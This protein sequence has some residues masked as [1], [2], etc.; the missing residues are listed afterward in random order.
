[1]TVKVKLTVSNGNDSVVEN[2][3]CKCPML[4]YIKAYCPARTQSDQF[5]I[6]SGT[7]NAKSIIRFKDETNDAYLNTF[8]PKA[9]TTELKRVNNQIMA[10]CTACKELMRV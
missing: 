4:N 5:V 2:F 7:E 1:M 9:D 3:E 8:L 10:V 6:Q